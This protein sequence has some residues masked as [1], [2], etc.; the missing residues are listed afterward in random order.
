LNRCLFRVIS[1]RITHLAI[2]FVSPWQ[3]LIFRFISFYFWSS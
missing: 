3:I 1:V 2:F